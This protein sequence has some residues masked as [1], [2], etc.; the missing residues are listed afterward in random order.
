MSD[1]STNFKDKNIKYSS[2]CNNILNKSLLIHG[3]L[4]SKH[5]EKIKE[6]EKRDKIT[7]IPWS[8]W[9]DFLSCVFR[10]PFK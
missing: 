10:N 4:D 2:F 7:S 1:F 3:T 6:F 8:V 5:Q 9:Y